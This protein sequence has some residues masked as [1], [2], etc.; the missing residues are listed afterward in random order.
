MGQGGIPQNVSRKGGIGQVVALLQQIPE[1]KR[2]GKGKEQ[3]RGISRSHINDAAFLDGFHKSQVP[4]KNR[5]ADR[6]ASGRRR[7][8][9]N[10]FAPIIAQKRMRRINKLYGL[11]IQI[12]AYKYL[13][14]SIYFARS[15]Y[16]IIQSVYGKSA[17]F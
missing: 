12:S 7:M 9:D 11:K 10:R 1:K 14:F 17:Y 4:F 8:E 16:K 15:A 6:C 2:K 13:T 3:A 5:A